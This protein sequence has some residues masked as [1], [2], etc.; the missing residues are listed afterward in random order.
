MKYKFK[1]KVKTT[2]PPRLKSRKSF[3]L[4]YANSVREPD[5]VWSCG[6]HQSNIGRIDCIHAHIIR[7]RNLWINSFPKLYDSI[8]PKFGP[9][10]S[11]FWFYLLVYNEKVL[12]SPVVLLFLDCQWRRLFTLLVTRWCWLVRLLR[13]LTNITSLKKFIQIKVSLVV[14]TFHALLLALV[15]AYAKTGARFWKKHANWSIYML[16]MFF[17]QWWANY[18]TKVMK[19]LH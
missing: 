17:R 7:N 16:L 2:A 8:R 10:I 11:F 12:N 19:L 15:Y 3:L 13:N 5:S 9:T 4:I 18:C 14:F 1:P 6:E